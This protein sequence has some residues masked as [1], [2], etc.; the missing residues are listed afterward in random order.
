MSNIVTLTKENF[1]EII[2]S[3][4]LVVVDFWAE[5]CG[6]CKNFEKIYEEVAQQHPTFIFGKV[7]T[8]EQ[9]ELA[10]DFN[11]RSIPTLMILREKIMVYFEAGVLPAA[12]LND[13]LEQTKALNIDEI[14]QQLGEIEK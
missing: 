4:S 2:S 8:E 9:V 13:L 7:N 6:P 10:N 3:N 11:I 5:W 14:R 1:D 12:A